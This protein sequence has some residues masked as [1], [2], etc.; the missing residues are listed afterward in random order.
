MDGTEMAV[1][2]VRLMNMVKFIPT[3]FQVGSILM[4]NLN[5]CTIR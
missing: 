2:T 4:N 5:T 3:H 1:Q